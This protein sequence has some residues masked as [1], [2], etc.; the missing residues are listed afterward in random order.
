MRAR[1]KSDPG[2][3]LFEVVIAVGIFAAAVTVMV[4]LL[5]PLTRQSTTALEIQNALHLPD[6]VGAELERVAIAGGFDALAAQVSALSSPAPETLG[7]V[8]RRDALMAQSLDYQPPPA[9]ERIA[10]DGQYF[11]IEVWKYADS[12]LGFEAGGA[13]IS[14]HVRISWP[15]H[16]PNS[17]SVTSLASR[18][19]VTF[20]LALRR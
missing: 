15:Y 9:G 17:A 5:S 16:L 6:A 10:E 3:S 4:G 19:Q 7:L 13:S 20:N 2:F 14:F 1:F 8:A 11:R 12:P 18:E